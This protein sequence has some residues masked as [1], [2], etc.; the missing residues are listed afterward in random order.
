MERVVRRATVATALESKIRER[1][2]A[3]KTTLNERS[4]RLWAAAEA[5]AAGPG[6]ISLVSRATG[7]S[8][9]TIARGRDEW[10]LFLTL[11]WDWFSDY[12]GHIHVVG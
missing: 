12:L 4:R 5:K 7:I 3:L 2:D 10:V 11:I 8:R 1:F 6:S 9:D